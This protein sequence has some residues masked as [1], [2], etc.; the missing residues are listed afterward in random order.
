MYDVTFLSLGFQ[1]FKTLNGS[2]KSKEQANV[3][4]VN[5]R[6]PTYPKISL[7]HPKICFFHAINSVSRNKS[8][9]AENARS[10]PLAH[11]TTLLENPDSVTTIPRS[12]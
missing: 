12:A 4:T 6:C 3:R 9:V 2:Q 8:L 5:H 11:K 7:G 1:S 10:T